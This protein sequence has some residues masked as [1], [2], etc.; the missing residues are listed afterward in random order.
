MDLKSGQF[1]QYGDQIVT[2]D[3]HAGGEPIRL[4]IDGLPPIPGETTND[5]RLYVGE[6][7]D[8]IRLLLTREPRGHRDMFAG[9]IT[10]AVSEDGDFG[11]VFMDPR[12][13]PYMCGHGTIGA[14]TAFL[15]MGWLEVREPETVVTVD[16]PAGPVRARARL[17]APRRTGGPGGVESVAIELESAFVFSEH[18]VLDVPGWGSLTLDVAFAGGFGLLIS[19]EQVGLALTPENAPAL[20]RCGM[21]AIAAANRQLEVQHP[22][23]LYM[24]TVDSAEFYDPC[25]DAEGRGKNAVIYGEGHIDRSA[26]GTGTSIKMALLHQRGQLDVGER[27][28]NQSILGTTFEGCI[29]RE[30]TVG[31]AAAGSGATFPAIVPEIRGTAHVIGLHRFTATPEDPFPEGFL[32]G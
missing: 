2:L 21:A 1:L 11:I 28:V 18:Q 22:T 3:L 20:A 9:I 6:H 29:L 10:D 32:V 4:V 27:Y 14:V 13:Y 5:K 24:D 16:A 15:E 31:E 7:L 17:Q 8:H 12:R 19:N 23:R 26:C 30:T 25:Q